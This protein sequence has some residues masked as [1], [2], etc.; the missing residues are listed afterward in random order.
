[1]AGAEKHCA[2]SGARLEGW[3]CVRVALARRLKSNQA[4]RRSSHIKAS[5]AC[6][7]TAAARS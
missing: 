5:I 6:C 3:N 4:P 7:L 1:M 2:Q